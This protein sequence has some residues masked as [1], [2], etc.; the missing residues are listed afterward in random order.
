MPSHIHTWKFLKCKGSEEFQVLSCW[1]AKLIFTINQRLLCF[2]LQGWRSYSTQENNS[3]DFFL[4]KSGFSDYSCQY[5]HRTRWIMTFKKFNKSSPTTHSPLYTTQ[6]WLIQAS[7]LDM[8]L[9]LL[10]A[11][12]IR[13]KLTWKMELPCKAVCS[14]PLLFTRSKNKTLGA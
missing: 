11:Q 12:L 7:N 13:Y 4:S 6:L 1:V 9:L 8:W 3:V 14:F 5:Y 10:K 2:R